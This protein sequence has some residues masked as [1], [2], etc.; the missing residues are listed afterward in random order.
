MHIRGIVRYYPYGVNERSRARP[1]PQGGGGEARA[2][3]DRGTRWRARR[4]RAE[5]ALE[6]MLE[7]V[8]CREGILISI[9]IYIYENRQLST[10]E[11]ISITG[12]AGQP[13]QHATRRR[14]TRHCT[15]NMSRQQARA[16][17]I[18]SHGSHLSRL[19]HQGTEIRERASQGAVRL[20]R[21]RLRRR[22]PLAKAPLAH[23]LS[24]AG[25]GLGCRALLPCAAF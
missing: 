22:R 15:I 5:R 24:E 12:Q 14:D 25:G 6:S 13:S 4:V 1:R 10:D 21:R 7:R 9:F 19:T 3:R 8:E 11:T 2:R 16:Y 20:R 18:M 23:V 17:I